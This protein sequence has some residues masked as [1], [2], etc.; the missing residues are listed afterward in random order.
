MTP[1]YQDDEALRAAIAPHLS[2]AAFARAIGQLE[3]YGFPK[4]DPLFKGRYA[5]AVRAWLDTHQGLNKTGS[6]VQDG[7]ETWDNGGAKPDSGIDRAQTKI[8]P[9]SAVL[10]RRQTFSQGEGIPGALDPFTERRHRGGNPRS[11]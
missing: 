7:Q 2:R 9:R 4:V 1:L 10:E 8:R 5:P 3:R 11:M 6:Q